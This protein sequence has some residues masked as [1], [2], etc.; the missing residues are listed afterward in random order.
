MKK[1]VKIV[2]CYDLP[3]NPDLSV[4]YRLLPK[5]PSDDYYFERTDRN[6][7]WITREE[8]KMLRTKTIGIAGCGGMGGALGAIFVR[9]GVGEVRICDPEV[10]DVS[11]IN[12]QYGAM[13][14]TVGKN[15]A[16][17]TA[18]LIRMTSDDTT[19]VVYPQ[20]FC[21][22]MADDFVEGCDVICDQIEFWATGARVLLHQKTRHYNIPNFNCDTVG[23][24]TF[25]F[26]F[27]ARST[28]VEDILCLDLKKAEELQKKIQA[29]KASKPEIRF[30]MDKIFET[31]APELP[32]YFNGN[33]L[34]FEERLFEEGKASIICPNPH[35]AGGFFADRVLL[36]LLKE[37]G[38]VERNE[39]VDVPK[40]PGYL[41][42]DAAMM[43]IKIVCEKWWD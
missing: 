35:M 17:E 26:L 7:G 5:N 3:E 14:C 1:G 2:D 43:R 31:F 38:V 28:K 30:V 8:Q 9:L 4:A 42:F 16:F 23:F 11:N 6:I 41:Y 19:L 36:Y 24:R 10:F 34:F 29:K 32:E 18:R 20:G 22:D 39:V 15:K 12:R 21:A 25:I 13:R 40:M 37:F 27:T 33:R